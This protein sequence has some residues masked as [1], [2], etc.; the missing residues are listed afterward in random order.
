MQLL[1]ENVDKVFI[2][3][4]SLF[5]I[6]KRVKI[7]GYLKIVNLNPVCEPFTRDEICR[8]TKDL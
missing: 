8:L 2:N 5:T 7:G 3:E 4:K 6:T 1:M